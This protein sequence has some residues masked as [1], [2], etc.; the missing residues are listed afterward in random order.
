MELM[1]AIWQ[2]RAVRS[3]TSEPVL[4]PLM[5][6]L[7]DAAIWAQSA[8]NEQPWV[9]TIIV[10]PDLIDSISA[11]AKEYMRA[12]AGTGMPSCLVKQLA[13]PGF[14]IF[15]HAPALVVI[16]TDGPTA[17]AIE[18]CAM[19]TENFMLAACAEGLGTC[20]VGLAQEWLGTPEGR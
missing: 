8:T 16:S 9:F 12:R 2:R 13:D 15:H 10:K 14:Q 18:D 3:Y 5:R 17:W 7:I 19:A 1:D 6:Q 11:S 20:F 4:K